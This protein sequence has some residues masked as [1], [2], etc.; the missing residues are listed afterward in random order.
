MIQALESLWLCLYE[1]NKKKWVFPP[2][3]TVFVIITYICFLFSDNTFV[4]ICSNGA[5]YGKA[6]NLI[7]NGSQP[8]HS[9]F[10]NS[11]L[12]ACVIST[13]NCE[14]RARLRFQ[15]VDIRLQQNQDITRCHPHSLFDITDGE[16]GSHPRSYKCS[17]NYFQREY[18][19]LY[20]SI[21]PY[22][23]ISLYNKPELN[24]SQLWLQIIGMYY[25]NK[26]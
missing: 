12:C 13:S 26:N 11:N 15:A 19:D 17:P 6:V 23:R 21:K 20:F 8:Q 1:Q 25:L 10:E 2:K 9:G 16:Y 18:N 4:D 5:V 22:A 3:I 7:L 14:S 24:I